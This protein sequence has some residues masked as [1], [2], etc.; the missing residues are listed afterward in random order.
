VSSAHYYNNGGN[1]MPGVAGDSGYLQKLDFSNNFM[2]LDP[3]FKNGMSF[4]ARIKFESFT[5]DARIFGFITRNDG[6]QRGT[7][8]MEVSVTNQH[9]EN[10]NAASS[11]LAFYVRGQDPNNLQRTSEGKVTV[12]GAAR[13]NE[14]EA[15]LF[16]YNAHTK[17]MAMW[18]NGIELDSIKVNLQMDGADFKSLMVGNVGAKEERWKK[19]SVLDG[20]VTDIRVWSR[21]V[22]WDAA[23]AGTPPGADPTEASKEQ[24]GEVDAKCIPSMRNS[25]DFVCD[26]ELPAELASSFGYGDVANSKKVS[27]FKKR[28]QLGELATCGK[29]ISAKAVLYQGKFGDGLTAEYF[30]LRTTCHLPP[31]LFGSMP[32]M[33]RVDPLVKFTGAEFHAPHNELVI[34]WTG[35]ILIAQ[36]GSYD[37]SVTA[38]DAA[39]VAIDGRL[40]VKVSGCGRG[41]AESRTKDA[42]RGLEKGAHDI[43]V[44]Y[45]NKGPEGQHQGKMELQYKGADTGGTLVPVP[46]A[47]LGS[48]PLRLAKLAKELGKDKEKNHSIAAVIPGAFIYDD[49]NRVGI[50]PVGSCGLQCQRGGL[51]SSGAYFKF[52]CPTSVE[53]TFTAKVNKNAKLALMWLDNG[54][55]MLWRMKAEKQTSSGAPALEQ[56]EAKEP[57]TAAALIETTATAEQMLSSSLGLGDFKLTEDPGTM[58]ISAPSNQIKLSA[59]EHTLVLQGR[60]E[61]DEFFA[62]ADL[63]LTGAASVCSFYLEGRDKTSTDCL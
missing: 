37:F 20:A 8:R 53:G 32:T 5:P 57:S 41:Q 16:I 63:R 43:S 34:R 60:P 13:A 47:K 4:F 36:T 12:P 6:D 42:T 61:R 35:K 46:T 45:L 7:A 48:A 38:D 54:D 51:K 19:N 28:E 22:T 24:Q 49:A 25:W 11:G 3:S 56:E 18:R 50:M 23:V 55:S 1:F 27:A 17:T 62:L 31:F 44:L 40:L 2:E 33:V 39:W 58:I 59:G 29:K 26:S 14:V 10:A 30:K 9:W 21:A 52:F 15:F